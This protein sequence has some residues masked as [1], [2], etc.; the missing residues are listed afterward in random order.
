M[1][2]RTTH[3]TAHSK[4]LQMQQALHKMTESAAAEATNDD[5]QPDP[6]ARQ[7]SRDI[8]SSKGSA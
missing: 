2:K 6:A 8:P 1:L 5:A 7:A 3:A 4:A